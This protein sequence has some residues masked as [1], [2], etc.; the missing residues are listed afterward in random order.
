MASVRAPQMGA[1]EAESDSADSISGEDSLSPEASA[2]LL[3]LS[4]GDVGVDLTWDGYWRMSLLAGGSFG[5]RSADTAYPGLAQGVNFNQEPDLTLSLWIEDRWFLET[6]FLEGFERNTYRAGYQGRDD[7]FIRQVVVGNAGVNASTY[8][9]LAVPRPVEN[10]PGIVGKFGTSKSDHEI[11]VRYDP[12][13]ALTKTFR[14]QYEVTSQEIGLSDFVEGRYFILPDEDVSNV[15]VYLEDRNGNVTG[16]DGTGANRRYRKAEPVEFFVDEESGLLELSEAHD[17]QVVVYYENSSGHPVGDDTVADFIVT[18]DANFRPDLTEPIVYEPFNLDAAPDPYDPQGR[19]FAD[20]SQVVIGGVDHLILYDPGRFTPFERQNVYLSARPLPEESWRVLP[21]LKDR[22]ALYPGSDPGELDFISDP[23]EKTVTAFGAVGSGARAPANRYPF[24]LADPEAYGPGREKDADKIS[25]VLVLT[26]RESNPGYNLGSGVVP[27]SVTVRVNGVLDTTVQVTDEGSLQFSRYIHL[28]DW[29]EVSYRTETLD[30]DG[31]DLFIYQGNRFQITPDLRWELAE[32]LRW[33]INR[34]RSTTEF[35]E[36][37]GEISVASTM[38]WTTETAGASVSANT[39]LATPD[40]SG[41]LRLFGMDGGGYGLALFNDNLVAAPS[42]VL[43]EPNRV[44]LDRYNYIS[45]DAFGREILND[46]IWPGASSTGQDGP[47]LAAD[48][49]GDP[50]DGRVMELRFN[51]PSS[52]DWSAGDALTDVEGPIDLSGYTALE[53]PIRFLNAGGNEPTLILQIGEI[54]ESADHQDDGAIN[55]AD[56][57]SYVEWNLSSD[58]DIEWTGGGVS[59]AWGGSWATARITL[60]ALDRARLE[61]ARSWRLLIKESTGASS[62]RL[63]TGAPKFEGSAFRTEIRGPEPT[64]ILVATQDVAGDEIE[65]NSLKSDFPEVA[66]LFHPNGESNQT[67]RIRWGSAAGGSDIAVGD[68][69]EAVSWFSGVP[70][71]AYRT[72]VFYIK[73]SGTTDPITARFTDEDDKGISVTWTPSGSTQWTKITVDIAGSSASASSGSILGSPVINNDA[74]ELTRILFS[75]TIAADQSG[76]LYLDEIH[77]TDPAYSITGGAEFRGYWRY[78]EDV[79][80]VGRFPILGNISLE[81][82]TEFAGGKVVSG[83]DR[84][85]TAVTGTFSAG[86]DVLG[87]GVETDWRTTWGQGTEIWSGSHSLRIP[88]RYDVFWVGDSYS[89]GIAGNDFTFSRQN[90]MNLVFR[91]GRARI[92]GEA[93]YDGESLVQA[94]GGETGWGGEHWDAKLDVRYVMNTAEEPEFAGD[95]FSSWIGDYTYL[96]PSKETVT[97]REAHHEAFGSFRWGVFSVEWDPEVRIKAA[98]APE[99]NQENRWAGRLS[100]PLTFE[101]WSV[102]PSY[103]RNLRQLTGLSTANSS[104][105]GDAW[106]VYAEGLGGQFPLFTYAPFREIFGKEDGTVFGAKTDGFNEADYETELALEMTRVGGSRIMDLFV[107][108]YADAS[109]ERRYLRKGDTFGWE[110][111][112]RSSVGFS[113]V[114]FFGRFGRYPVIPIYNTEEIS[115]LVQVNLQDENGTGV[116]DPEELVWQADW[117][118]GGTRNRKLVLDHRVSWHWDSDMRKTMQEGRVEYRWRTPSKD[119]LHLPLVNRAIPKQHHL[120]NTERIG[121]RGLYPWSDAP[122]ETISDLGFLLH[123]ESSWVFQD[124]GHFKG[125]LTL[126]LGGR[127]GEFVNGWELGMEAE[128]RF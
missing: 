116:P 92:F 80:A 94:W 64:N 86:A 117:S 13:E 32:S 43:S 4:L 30:L 93:L 15:Q 74:G 63:I 52:G 10:T 33:N 9:G 34:E 120:E 19:D 61:K 26:I 101:S 84:G 62:G 95:Y 8:A 6:T 20:T 82:G 3:D 12:S 106:G 41:N 126:G 119:V 111:E 72:A 29:I 99:W 104:S 37:S 68:R 105:Y 16:T 89:M 23:A 112:W 115:G 91:P 31:G 87:V 90:D 75:S 7:E 113:A 114:N 69:W 39:T 97:N 85:N 66:E 125:W 127:D 108:S 96:L 98:R 57:G 51:L 109:L 110:N 22:G 77:F 55:G 45:Y 71:E 118:F 54:G 53:I 48:R 47:G 81:G 11:L 60:T 24:A 2:Y 70:M 46:Y 25:R 79:A 14:G 83:L 78:P 124:T 67:M 123:H 40:T 102:T 100:F 49:D 56:A 28:D 36:S 65:D 27:G 17:G 59:G 42:A 76:T 88:A 35:G 38:D 50:T 122:A 107:P 58:T 1:Q 128:F 121:V 5:R 21:L 73:D 18:P 44:D 103:R